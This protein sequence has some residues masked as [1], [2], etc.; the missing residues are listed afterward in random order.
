MYGSNANFMVP[1]DKI[2]IE[3][4]KANKTFEHF[5]GIHSNGTSILKPA[6][7][8]THPARRK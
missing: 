6:N 2:G 7:A 4:L 1:I 3:A 5:S 8:D